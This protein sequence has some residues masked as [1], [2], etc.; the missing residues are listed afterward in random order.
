LGRSCSE[1]LSITTLGSSFGEPLWGVA[2]RSSFGEQLRLA[3]QNGF[4]E[5][6]L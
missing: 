1:Q 2:L 6:L 3:F 5:Q 4:A